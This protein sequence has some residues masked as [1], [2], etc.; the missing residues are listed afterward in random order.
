MC[1]GSS[2]RCV[3]C[4]GIQQTTIL[5]DNVVCLY[6]ATNMIQLLQSNKHISTMWHKATYFEQS[7]SPQ[8]SSAWQAWQKLADPSTHHN[9]ITSTRLFP[10]RHYIM[11]FYHPIFSHLAYHVWCL[12]SNANAVSTASV[13][14][15]YSFS[16]LSRNSY[17]FVYSIQSTN[18]RL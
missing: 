6:G 8:H 17:N 5:K 1:S 12:P 15:L 7:P 16:Q 14:T 18:A 11:S 4:K 10:P 3:Q 2:Y 9:V 13:S